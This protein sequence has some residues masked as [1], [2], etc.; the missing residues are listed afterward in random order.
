MG[1]NWYVATTGSNSYAG[2]SSA[3]PFLTIQYAITAAA[4]GDVINVAAGTYEELIVIDKPITLNGPNA[5]IA[6]NGSRVPEAVIQFPAG[7]A[8]ES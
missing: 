7:A 5:T 6:G 4:A 2:T 8:D 1:T 3:V